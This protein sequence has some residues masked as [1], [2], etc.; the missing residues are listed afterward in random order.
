MS[1]EWC[2]SLDLHLLKWV[3]GGLGGSVVEPLPLARGVIPGPGI[4]S[5]IKLPVG[6][7]LL[8]L[9]LSVSLINK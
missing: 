8:P 1:N 2:A 4:E 3:K 6:S 9:P 5:H 7:L